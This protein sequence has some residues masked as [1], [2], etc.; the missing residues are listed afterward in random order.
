[1]A[2]KGVFFDLGGTLFSYRNMGGTAPL[3]S[4]ACRRMDVATEQ[5]KIGEAYAQA[6]R[7][8]SVTYADKPYYL[9]KDLFRD[10]FVRFTQVL[11]AVFDAEVYAWYG[12][13]Q[14]QAVLDNL[15][16]KE[17]CLETLDY[18]KTRG[19]Y[20]SIVSNIDDDMLHSLVTREG[21]GEFLHHWTSSE[22]A[23]SCKPDS[24]FF[25]IGLE[26]ARL[27]ADS[28]LFVGDSPEHD[29][30]GASAVGMQTVLIV[31]EGVQ[32]PLQTGRETVAPNHRI[33]QLSELRRLA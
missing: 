33:E 6:V 28:V 13:R 24:R 11:G 30:A 26:K 25:E 5:G 17:D 16:L 21:L 10:T 3:L 18:L 7:D 22:A 4:E 23:G 19:L 20:L 12:E 31:E 1:M 14:H 9:H 15:Y 8:I 29:I 2:V 27:T 32:P